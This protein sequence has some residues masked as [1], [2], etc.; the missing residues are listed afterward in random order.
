MFLN[1]QVSESK[2]FRKQ[3]SR[4]I[5]NVQAFRSNHDDYCITLTETV[6]AFG[7][8]NWIHA[9]F[10]IKNLAKYLKLKLFLF[11]FG[12]LTFVCVTCTAVYI[13][14]QMWCFLI[15]IFFKWWWKHWGLGSVKCEKNIGAQAWH[16]VLFVVKYGRMTYN[17]WRVELC[18]LLWR[19]GNNVTVKCN[20]LWFILCIRSVNHKKMVKC[21]YVCS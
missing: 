5:F 14:S 1:R 6:E 15:H 19:R 12:Y 4:V 3:R 13:W 16:K 18:T 11:I 17:L 2:S 10:R 21:Y 20:D 9:N 7:N 8:K